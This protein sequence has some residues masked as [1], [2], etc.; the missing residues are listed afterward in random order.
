MPDKTPYDRPS[1]FLSGGLPEAA[2]EDA[3]TIT[4][5][6]QGGRGRGRPPAEAPAYA[7]LLA[8]SNFSFLRGASHPEE[9][10][11]TA[12]DLGL[13]GLAVTDRNTLA[14]SVRAHAA[15]RETRLKSV[16]GCRLVFADGKIG[17]AHV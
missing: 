14:G 4:P 10:A 6:P 12:R 17:R 3:G 13:A 16:V 2:G 5:F 11:T 15:A 1:H 8:A 7:E 9:L